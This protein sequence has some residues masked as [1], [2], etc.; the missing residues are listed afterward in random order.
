MIMTNI[1]PFCLFK[2]MEVADKTKILNCIMYWIFPPNILWPE[3][4]AK[5][6]FLLLLERTQSSVNVG[7]TGITS[8]H[9]GQ[10][11]RECMKNE[12]VKIVEVKSEFLNVLKTHHHKEKNIL[13]SRKTYYLL[14]SLWNTIPRVNYTTS[15]PYSVK[16]LT[17]HFWA[18]FISNGAI[19]C[20]TK[21][22]ALW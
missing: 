18:R 12:E 9:R 2:G 10:P 3:T 7:F 1:I 5:M 21:H 6:S 11:V 8:I 4:K 16:Y 13:D 15:L 14:H 19:L 22:G 17:L 20:S